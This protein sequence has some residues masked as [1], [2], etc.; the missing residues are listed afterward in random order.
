MKPCL[1]LLLGMAAY[2]FAAA[3][4]ASG[5][6]IATDSF[7][8]TTNG[9]G[10]TYNSTTNDGRLYG[11]NPTA[12]NTGFSGAWGTLNGNATGDL[13]AQ[14]G[15]LTHPLVVNPAGANDGSVFA[16]MG[17]A[18]RMITRPF[19]TFS[20][21]EPQYFMSV[22]FQAATLPTTT[23]PAFIGFGGAF[24]HDVAPNN[25]L[26][27]GVDDAGIRLYYRNTGG[28]YVSSLVTNQIAANTTYQLVV[29][30]DANS[31]AE[32]DELF[33]ASVYDQTGAQVGSPFSI[34]GSLDIAG[35][36]FD[37]LL[38]H[39]GG[40]AAYSNND[41]TPRFDEFRFGTTLA[42]VSMIPE[43]GSWAM[44]AAGGMALLL[45]RRKSSFRGGEE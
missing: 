27:I 35:A 19:A 34:V 36:E 6:L 25:G 20:R 15:G 10:G 44:L 2:C 3:S 45:Y 9:A 22:L 43:P 17:G 5:A 29:Q 11:I 42:D 33:T 7:L 31:A 24:N 32:G 16:H 12:G 23:N 26:Q 21:A 28:T 37:R 1:S 38:L 13:R 40:L 4:V 14:I 8:T 30:I 41:N 39:K 18:V